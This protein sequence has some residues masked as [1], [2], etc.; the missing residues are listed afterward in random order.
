MPN[1]KTECFEKALEDAGDIIAE[2]MNTD[3]GLYRAARSLYEPGRFR[4]RH[5]VLDTPF[6]A[7]PGCDVTKKEPHRD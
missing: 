3:K 2:S 4:E 6:E 1:L 5:K 7:Y